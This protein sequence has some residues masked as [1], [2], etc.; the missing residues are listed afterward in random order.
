MPYYIVNKNIDD[1]GRHEVHQDTC[2]RLPNK[3]NQLDI[4]YHSD[5]TEAIQYIQN[6]NPAHLFDGCWYCSPACNKG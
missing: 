3:E 4:G 6:Q 1:N 2:T 5:C